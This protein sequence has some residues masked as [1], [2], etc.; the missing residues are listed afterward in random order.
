VTEETTGGECKIKRSAR[1]NPQSTVSSL[2]FHEDG[3]EVP[4]LFRDGSGIVCFAGYLT[5]PT[6]TTFKVAASAE[7][8][9]GVYEKSDTFTAEAG[10][11]SPFGI[12]IDIP[13]TD[14]EEFFADLEAELSVVSEATPEWVDVF[15]LNL[16]SIEWEDFIDNIEYE[17]G[18]TIQTKFGQRTSITV[19]YLYYL[20]QEDPLPS[21][22]SNVDVESF[23]EGQH[24]FLK[25]CNRCA[26]YLPT[27]YV[28]EKERNLT[29]FGNHCVSRAPCNHSAFGSQTVIEEE[30][31]LDDLPEDLSDKLTRDGGD[32]VVDLH[33]GYQ[34]ECKACKKFYVN[35]A[36]NPMRNSTQHR[37]D[38]LRRRAIEVLVRKLLD[39]NWIYHSFRQERDK[40][41]DKHIWERFSKECFKCGKDI[42]SPS[43]MDLDHTMPLAALWP[44]DEHATCLCSDCNSKKSDQYPIDFYTDDELQA[45]SEVTGLEMET[46]QS[47]SINREAV[48]ALQNRIVWFF[49]EFLSAE[50]YQK[51]RNGKIVADL[52]VRAIQDRIDESELQVDLVGEY[53][54]RTGSN[55][56]SISLE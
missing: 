9:D 10:E 47:R 4:E 18:S 23:D 41:F 39:E 44:L 21:I 13:L 15:G 49:D 14:V 25:S 51:D 36:L 37:E 53:Q 38:A 5:V 7:L 33:Y 54:S 52:I 12:H 24:T 48:E 8:E 45:L 50:D 28:P 29:S 6:E 22:P 17:D 55:P 43:E 40:E 46:L 42:K 20:N 31:D 35:A 30:S 11:W 26:R 32:L 56:E 2:I 16:S 27:E 34:L 3:S 19:P 1:W